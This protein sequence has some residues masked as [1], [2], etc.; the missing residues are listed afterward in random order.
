MRHTRAGHK[1]SQRTL[2]TRHRDRSRAVRSWTCC[3]SVARCSSIDRAFRL[4]AGYAGALAASAFVGGRIA[5]AAGDDSDTRKRSRYSPRQDASATTSAAGGPPRRPQHASFC[6]KFRRIDRLPVEPTVREQTSS[7]LRDPDRRRF[8]CGRQHV[9][10]ALSQGPNDPAWSK[11]LACADA[12]C[13]GTGRISSEMSGKI[14]PFER[15]R[16]LAGLKPLS[17][18][19]LFASEISAG[20]S[21][22]GAR[23]LRRIGT[24]AHSMFSTF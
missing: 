6:A 12:P 10:D 20:F 8:E 21:R 13:A 14:I 18:Q 23:S 19:R 15:P 2:G 1:S 7:R 11:N 17:P 16:K 5:C 3:G 24:N 4:G 22:A 9:S